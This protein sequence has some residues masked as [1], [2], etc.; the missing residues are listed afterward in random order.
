MLD[1]FEKTAP[2]RTK[3]SALLA[4]HAGL[5]ILSLLAIVLAGQGYAYTG[6]GLVSALSR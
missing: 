2:I 4:V 5:S 1:W 6:L 3:F